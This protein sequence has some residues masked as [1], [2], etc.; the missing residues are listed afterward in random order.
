MADES[1]G[2]GQRLL[3]SVRETHMAYLFDYCEGLLRDPA[4]AARAVQETFST[5]RA[6]ID[7]L[8]DA[9][10]LRLWLY[11]IARRQ[12]LDG[13]SRESGPAAPSR[14][15]QEQADAAEAETASLETP[16][17]SD[18]MLDPET[19]VIMNAALD[20]LSDRDQEMLRLAF[21]HDFDE[22]ELAA[23]LGVS[24][25]RARGL[26]SGAGTRFEESAAVAAVVCVGYGWAACPTLERFFGD[27][28]PASPPLTPQLRRRLTPHIRSCDR[29][30]ERRGT[31]DLGPELLGLMPVA[32]APAG[33]WP[34]VKAAADTGRGGYPPGVP[35]LGQ[36]GA[37]GFP[38]QPGARRISRRTMAAAAA[39]LVVLAGAGA[40]YGKLA[41]SPSAGSGR[42]AADLAAGA[43]GTPAA[44]SPGSPEA[45]SPRPARTSPA[46]H[47]GRTQVPQVPG[48]SP[49][50]A[51]VLPVPR[52]YP[53]TLSPS[54][55]PT[56]DSGSPS[57]R[58]THH[59][60]TPSP[61]SPSPRPTSPSPSPTPTSPSP[62]PTSPSPSPTSPSPPPV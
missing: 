42:T 28:D 25:R 32:A 12:C 35:G 23:V 51:G 44:S 29:C 13:V 33:L 62:S 60:P 59:S 45:V 10:R 41:S 57:P 18:G 20:A 30:A 8:Q 1:R 39:L 21:R 50:P 19:L 43:R 26:L 9:R 34:Q 48:L 36:L 14:S 2:T 27:W 49:A 5:A 17:A 37:D 4:A 31:R 53:V 16:D 47:H 55:A 58:P 38:D 56:H 46:R 40:W 24:P 3:A 61:T 7:K 15:P 11:S 54:P 22:T 6:E 52:T